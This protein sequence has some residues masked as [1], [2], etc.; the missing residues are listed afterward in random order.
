M[1]HAADGKH[2]HESASYEG[3]VFDCECGES[4][5][6]YEEL[7]KHCLGNLA[8]DLKTECLRRV[9]NSLDDELKQTS[10]QPVRKRRI[11]PDTVLFGIVVLYILA[12]L[13]AGYVLGVSR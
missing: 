12:A 8:P 1:T 7:E 3:S 11:N 10:I 13:F 5:V 4:F 6:T 2:L 9:L